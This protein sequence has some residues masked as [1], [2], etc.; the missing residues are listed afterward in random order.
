M[1]YYYAV[2]RI[3]R[4]ETHGE[5]ITPIMHHQY[6]SQYMVYPDLY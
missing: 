5:I 4:A 3:A 6:I 1:L 2:Y